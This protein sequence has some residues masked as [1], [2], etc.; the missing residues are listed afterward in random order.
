M[1]GCVWL[2]LSLV[3]APEAKTPPLPSPT[4][5]RDQLLGEGEGTEPG[6]GWV[7]RLCLCKSVCWCIY[8]PVCFF[9]TVKL[10]LSMAP[11]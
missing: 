2:G 11:L 8:G 6:G 5:Y 9:L 7:R 4:F 10:K 1:H 3:D